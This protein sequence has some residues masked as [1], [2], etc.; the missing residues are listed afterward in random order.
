MK[1][2]GLYIKPHLSVD[3]EENSLVILGVCARAL[4]QLDIAATEI[5]RFR[6]EAMSGNR[7]H[8]IA[9]VQSVFEC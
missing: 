9:V 3:M 6:Q 8:L 7:E 1:I 4:R 2:D 5:R